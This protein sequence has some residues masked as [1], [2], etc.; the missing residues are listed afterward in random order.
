M[1]AERPREHFL[2]K[3]S[4]GTIT[5]IRDA[6]FFGSGLSIKD[7]LEV[8]WSEGTVESG[9]SGSGLFRNDFLIG[10]LHGGNRCGSNPDT[11]YYSS[12]ESMFSQV[13]PFLDP[14]S[15]DSQNVR[16]LAAPTAAV[17]ATSP[18]SLTEAN[19]DNATL[20]VALTNTSFRSGVT[21]QSFTL[22]TP[23]AGIWTAT[24]RQRRTLRSFAK[25]SPTTA[26]TWAAR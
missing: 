6:T 8:T 14:Q 1:I 18:A 12:F 16:N 5:D 26:P 19:L 3:Y 21:K 24:V 11:D 9:S 4:A 10:T 25:R 2:K 22:T 7:A 13:C 17:S 23:S 15:C 20:T